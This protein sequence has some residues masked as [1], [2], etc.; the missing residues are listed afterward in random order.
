MLSK[1]YQDQF[2]RNQIIGISK[3][4][5]ISQQDAEKIIEHFYTV[6]EDTLTKNGLTDNNLRIPRFGTFKI[7]PLCYYYVVK[8]NI[9]KPDFQKHLDLYYKMENE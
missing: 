6:I 2:H 9:G 8:N 7:S 5:N 3:E 4:Y 1:K